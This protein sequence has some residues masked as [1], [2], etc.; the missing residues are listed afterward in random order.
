MIN[1]I[2]SLCFHFTENRIRKKNHQK[3]KVINDFR[4]QTQPIDHDRTIFNLGS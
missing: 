3:R 1:Y 2:N 4:N